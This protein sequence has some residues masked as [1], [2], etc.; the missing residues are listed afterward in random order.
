MI[1][2][3]SLSKSSKDLLCG[4]PD[5]LITATGF[6]KPRHEKRDLCE[7]FCDNFKDLDPVLRKVGKCGYFL[8]T[9][10]TSKRRAYGYILIEFCL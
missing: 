4:I 3:D 5:V 2:I 1:L 6:R 7:T 9:L 10:F 8:C